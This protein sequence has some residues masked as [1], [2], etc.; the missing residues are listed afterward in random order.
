MSV[1]KQSIL[2]S[3]RDQLFPILE[4]ADVDVTRRD[5]S[6]RRAPIVNYGPS[7]FM[8]ELAQLS[9]RPAL[10]D[11]SA[12]GPVELLPIATKLVRSGSQRDVPQTTHAAQQ[13]SAQQ[14]AS[15]RSR[16]AAASSR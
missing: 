7:A 2:E 5:Q 16:L 9:G 12:Q 3:R 11:A 4:P 8:G 1:S 14:L 15:R 10:V 6:G 13:K